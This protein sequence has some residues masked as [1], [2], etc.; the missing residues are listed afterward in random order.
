MTPAHTAVPVRFPGGFAR[1]Q[2]PRPTGPVFRALPATGAPATSAPVDHASPQ[3]R[4]GAD[5]ASAPSGIAPPGACQ[6]AVRRRAP[7]ARQQQRKRERTGSP[8]ELAPASG[9]RR[10]RTALPPRLGWRRRP[11]PPR[12]RCPP[13]RRPRPRAVTVAGA[14]CS[15]AAPT[16]CRSRLRGPRAAALEPLVDD[17]GT[18]AVVLIRGQP[19]SSVKTVFGI[20]TRQVAVVVR[21]PVREAQSPNVT[22]RRTDVFSLFRGR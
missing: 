20:R 11:A 14:R 7:P 1:G 2:G 19:Q 18:V 10:S 4:L 21:V 9:P 15:L 16:R 13:S 22:M 6:L 3:H 12:P 8:A 17:A 5:G